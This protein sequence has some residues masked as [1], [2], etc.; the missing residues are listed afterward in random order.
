[1][2]VTK[3]WLLWFV[4][5]WLSRRGASDGVRATR[6][7]TPY[8][9][10]NQVEGSS[11]CPRVVI[12]VDGDGGRFQDFSVRM[13]MTMTEAGEYLATGRALAVMTGRNGYEIVKNH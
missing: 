7:D 4:N 13:C 10:Q 2:R 11:E 5:D 9:R 3:K 12:H 8:F 1:M 6:V